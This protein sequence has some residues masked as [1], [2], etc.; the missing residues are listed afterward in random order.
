VRDPF[1]ELCPPIIERLFRGGQ[2]H[3]WEARLDEIVAK[4]ARLGTAMPL[5]RE[6]HRELKY[7]WIPTALLF[8]V[9]LKLG[10]T[11]ASLTPP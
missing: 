8:G 6:T 11:T 3:A 5:A 2:I 10:K 4:Q 9:T 1:D 7:I